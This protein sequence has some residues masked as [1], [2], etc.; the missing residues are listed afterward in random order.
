MDGIFS[1]FPRETEKKREIKEKK[2]KRENREKHLTPWHPGSNME[3]HSSSERDNVFCKTKRPLLS[4]TSRRGRIFFF[5]SRKK[6][7]GV[8]NGSQHLLWLLLK[9]FLLSVPLSQQ[10]SLRAPN[11]LFLAPSC[12]RASS[13]NSD[14]SLFRRELPPHLKL[15][16]RCYSKTIH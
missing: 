14:L 9:Y 2:S 16:H 12:F 7:V 3:Q 6:K 15:A 8:Y 10:E 1:S 11:L 13:Q 5:F 4:L